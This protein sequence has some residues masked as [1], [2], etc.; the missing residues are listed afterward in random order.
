MK[1]E[2]LNGYYQRIAEEIDKVIP[3]KW[4]NAAIY[5]EDVG[6]ARSL[7]LVFREKEDS[8]YICSGDFPEIYGMSLDEFSR[9]GDKILDECRK[10]RNEFIKQSEKPWN[11]FEFFINNSG[12]F[13]AK[14]GYEYDEEISDYERSIVW[15]YREFGIMPRGD[16]GLSILNEFVDIET[17][18]LKKKM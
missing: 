12:E 3:N 17:G 15:H 9:Y 16:F 10:L 11:I 4:N 8:Q 7:D 14:F 5:V 18:E 2:I 1:E 6:N 13:K